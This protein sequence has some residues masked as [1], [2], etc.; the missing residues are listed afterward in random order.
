[1]GSEQVKIDL[2]SRECGN[3][4]IKNDR[5]GK[6]GRENTLI[7]FGRKGMNIALGMVILCRVED[8]AVILSDYIDG[9]RLESLVK[10]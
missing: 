6:L 2:G 7:P 8:R 10:V 3:S 5:R 1:M 9:L 4:K